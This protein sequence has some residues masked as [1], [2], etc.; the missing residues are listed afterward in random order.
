MSDWFCW[1]GA[2]EDEPSVEEWQAS[3]NLLSDLGV[4]RVAQNFKSK[5]NG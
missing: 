2:I 1:H 3:I 4:F 5:Q